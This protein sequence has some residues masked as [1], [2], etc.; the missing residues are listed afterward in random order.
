MLGHQADDPFEITG[1][2][3]CAEG[4]RERPQDF[5]RRDY[6]PAD[7]RDRE[8]LTCVPY[9]LVTPGRRW[10]PLQC[11]SKS[12]LGSYGFEGPDTAAVPCTTGHGGWIG[13][14][15]AEGSL[16]TVDD[17]DAAVR[18][19]RELDMALRAED[20]RVKGTVRRAA[21]GLPHGHFRPEYPERL[22]QVEDLVD[23]GP[24]QQVDRRAIGEHQNAALR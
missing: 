6:E 17:L 14:E 12:N 23:L 4:R 13:V 22:E 24:R 19:E 16:G 18:A 1:P 8:R 9:G 15:T 2:D 10:V 21:L 3:S 20:D 11:E 7:C 5:G